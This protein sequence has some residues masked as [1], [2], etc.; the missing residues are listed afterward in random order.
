MANAWATIDLEAVAANVATLAE[1]VAPA[2]VCAVVKADGYGHGAVPV[3]T[4]AIAAGATWLAVAHVGEGER[5]REAGI[6]H[7]ILV[8]SE[9]ES[10]DYARVAA[11][12]LRVTLFS[13][14]GIAAAAAAGSDDSPIGVH[15]KVDTGMHR[16]GVDPSDVVALA[17]RIADAPGLELEALWTHLAVADEP[18][19]PFT[20]TQLARY[21]A[22]LEALDAEGIPPRLRHAANSAGALAHPESR[23]DMVR[24]GIALYGIAPSAELRDLVPLRPAMALSARVTQVKQVAA[25]EAISYGLRHRFDRDTTVATVAIGYADWVRRDL[26][27]RGGEVLL[28]GRRC[29]I[30]G[31]VTMDQIMV[32]CGSAEVAVGDEAVLIGRQGGEEI[33]AAEVADRLD[34]IA[35]E[36][37]C[38]VGP[39]VERRWQGGRRFGVATGGSPLP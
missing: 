34:T 37:V 14:T 25:G 20:R 33:T 23:Y 36:V 35:Y 22:A 17:R 12:G 5:L 3:A 39:R 27:R 8:L 28:G 26:S 10:G 16:V 2:E 21:R 31:T 24:C 19:N 4:A 7:P 1:M 9:P 38:G 13:K 15:L 32:D 18:A 29:P 30:V 11:A 6:G